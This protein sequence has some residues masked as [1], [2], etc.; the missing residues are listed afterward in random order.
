M[1]NFYKRNIPYKL[2]AFLLAI[3][4]WVYVTNELNPSDS[5]VA[6]VPLETAGLKKGLA[7]VELPQTVKVRLQGKRNLMAASTKDV[8]AFV[9]LREAHSGENFATVDVIAPPGFQVLEKNPAKVRVVLDNMAVRQVPVKAIINGKPIPGYKA[10][11]PLFEPSQ[12]RVTGPEDLV[13]EI[14][15][16]EISLDIEGKSK[17]VNQ[18][19]PVIL[20]DRKGRQADPTIKVTPANIELTVPIYR[21][22]EVKQVKIQPRI[23]GTPAPGF[24]VAAVIV[25]PQDIFLFGSKELLEGITKIDTSEINIDGA[26]GETAKMAALIVPN[27][28]NINR[29]ETVKVFIQV[30]AQ[31]VEKTISNVNVAA[32]KADPALKV[33]INPQVVNVTLE[34][35]QVN[36]DTTTIRAF[37]N[38]EGLGKGTHQVNVQVAPLQGL[39][40]VAVEPRM[41]TVTLE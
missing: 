35:Q 10:L 7:I 34:G 21:E 19:L 20:Y 38:L 22:K 40:L 31:P 25:E 39:N 2:V 1:E 3:L 18:S 33:T 30:V 24:R 15:H 37:V 11:E 4:V 6:Q 23:T 12:V 5:L 29:S 17:T 9:N 13:K 8:R 14:G 36:P 16:A 28:I 26:K 27:G 41:V 32:E